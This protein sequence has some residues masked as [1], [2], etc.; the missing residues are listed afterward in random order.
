MPGRPAAARRVR[1]PIAATRAEP[2]RVGFAVGEAMQGETAA[3]APIF[4]F[5]LACSAVL[6]SAGFAVG[7]WL[8]RRDRR[9]PQFEARQAIEFLRGLMQ[10]T[11]GVAGEVAEYR[12][13]VED[14][15]KRI[16]PAGK[17]AV[18]E[19]D[20]AD[21]A[22][23]LLESVALANRR[24]KTRLDDAEAALRK[25]SAEMATMISAASTDSLTGLANRR[26]FEQELR[27]RFAEWRR[28][29]MPFSVLMVDVDFF[30]KV[31]D[32]LGHLAGD[33]VL[34]E[35]ASTL[36]ATMRETDLVARFGGEEFAVI[37]AASGAAD[38]SQAAERARVGIART[39]CDYDGGSVPVTVSCG[40]AQATTDDTP[41]RLI[42]RADKALYAAKHAGRNA[43]FWHDGRQCR[44][45]SRRESIAASGS[46][47]RIPPDTLGDGFAAIAEAVRR[48]LD[49]VTSGQDSEWPA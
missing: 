20:R 17:G 27:R 6:L 8:A 44:P 12:E 10:W 11:N 34:K 33:S 9:A 30:K 47:A 48:R 23:P 32:S 21:G 42:E 24:L 22:G 26:V 29:G 35:V 31:N 7:T 5:G 43:A 37:L 28:H 41:E 3:A 14:V 13:V 16:D 49:E 2:F 4:V 15:A 38:A 25:Q 1:I 46:P 40:V 18:G 39:P 19:P 45:L 36:R